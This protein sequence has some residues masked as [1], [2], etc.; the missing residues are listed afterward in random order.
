MPLMDVAVRKAKPAEK[1]CKLADGLLVTPSG[2]KLWRFKYRF[3]GKEKLLSFGPYPEISL[4]EAREK[5]DAA[6]KQL[7]GSRG[8]S[9]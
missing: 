9:R 1:P 8:V 7:R 2:G 5:R 3:L 6:K 4:A